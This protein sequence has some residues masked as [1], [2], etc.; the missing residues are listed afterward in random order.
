MSSEWTTIES[1]PGVFNELM[2][3]LGIEAL[4]W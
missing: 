3:M 1:D 2:Q 4:G